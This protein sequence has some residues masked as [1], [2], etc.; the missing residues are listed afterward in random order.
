[1][2]PFK[3]SLRVLIATS[4]V[5]GFLGGWALLAH[6]PKPAQASQ[7]PPAQVEQTQLPPLP[8]MPEFNSQANDFQPIPISPQPFTNFRGRMRTGGS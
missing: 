2:K 4:S 3:A 8:P 6:S 5:A 1:M 7:Q